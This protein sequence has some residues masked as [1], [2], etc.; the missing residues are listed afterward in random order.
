[1]SWLW[2]SSCISFLARARLGSQRVSQ[3][4]KRKLRCS[5]QAP[6]RSQARP[7]VSPSRFE[8]TVFPCRARPFV[9]DPQEKSGNPRPPGIRIFLRLP[10]KVGFVELKTP[11]IVSGFFWRSFCEGR[12]LQRPKSNHVHPSFSCFFSSIFD[13]PKKVMKIQGFPSRFKTSSPGTMPR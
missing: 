8:K 9:R 4:R 12:E 6:C 5:P 13:P 11:G 1:M 2:R 3:A 7:L 10:L